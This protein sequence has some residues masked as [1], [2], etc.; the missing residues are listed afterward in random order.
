[1]I[2]SPV[3][4]EFAFDAYQYVHIS[5]FFQDNNQNLGGLIEESQIG[6]KERCNHLTASAPESWPVGCEQMIVRSQC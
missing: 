6:I 1:M 3:C 4:V 5:A 2:P